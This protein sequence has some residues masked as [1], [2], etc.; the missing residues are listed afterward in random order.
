VSTADRE[1]SRLDQVVEAEP[2]AAVLAEA[3]RRN[4]VIH[5]CALETV[6]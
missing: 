2:D 1:L 6:H 3:D 4:G 5:L